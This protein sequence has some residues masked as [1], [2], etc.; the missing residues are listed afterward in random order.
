[1]G[2]INIDT[3]SLALK[4]YLNEARDL[5]M[6]YRDTTLPRAVAEGQT[7]CVSL[8]TFSSLLKVKQCYLE[9]RYAFI[10]FMLVD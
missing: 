3:L 2:P 8:R 10:S 4:R 5:L 1:M 9:H 6:S 7:G